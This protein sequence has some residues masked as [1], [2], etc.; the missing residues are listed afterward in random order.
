[1]IDAAV[2][3]VLAGSGAILAAI[4]IVLAAAGAFTRTDPRD[5]L[6]AWI[7]TVFGALYVG[8]LAFVVRLGARP[9]R[10]CRR[11]RRWRSSAASGLWVMIL[12]LA[13]WA[14]DTG[15]YLVGRRSGARFG[16][17]IGRERFLDP[18]LALED[19]CRAARRPGRHDASSSC[20]AC[21]AP[22]SRSSSA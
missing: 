1:M 21:G 19:V 6:N 11:E 7:G 3:T 13:V 2:P 14:Y 15:A 22:A 9:R 16:E 10:P 18:H 17:L 8:L 5:G 4:G 20:S 12:I